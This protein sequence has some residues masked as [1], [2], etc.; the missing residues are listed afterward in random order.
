[1]LAPAA[2][3]QRISELAED[4]AKRHAPSKA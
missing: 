4:L 3:R 2:A 1:V